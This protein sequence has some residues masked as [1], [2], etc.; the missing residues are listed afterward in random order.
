MIADNEE[1]TRALVALPR[2]GSVA[3]P[4]AAMIELRPAI[5][6]EF[7]YSMSVVCEVVGETRGM[8]GMN[9]NHPLFR[10]SWEAF[11]LAF[12]TMIMFVS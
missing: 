5:D 11:G 6:N 8:L 12:Q 4:L 3:I 10:V 7:R 1:I 9:Q 2:R